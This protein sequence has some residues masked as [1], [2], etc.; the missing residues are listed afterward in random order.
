M[1]ISGL[2]K[3]YSSGLGLRHG[4]PAVADVSFSISSGGFISVIGESGSGKTTLGK[5]ILRLLRPSAGTIKYKGRDIRSLRRDELRSYYREGQGIFQDPFSSFNPLYKVDRTFRMIYENFL[6]DHD[7][8]EFEGRV[9]KVVGMVDL[10]PRE[11]LGKYPHQLSGGQLQRLL[12]ARAL[13]MDVKL[14]IADEIISMLDAS[15]RA[16]ILNLLGKLA[17]EEGMA[18]LFITHDLS[19]GYYISAETMIMYKGR[20]VEYGLSEKVFREPVH[21]YTK[22]LF[23]SVPDIAAER[24]RSAQENLVRA[25]Q[26]MSKEDFLPEA[27]ARRVREFY[28]VNHKRPKGLVEVSEGHR[29]VLTV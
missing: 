21:P 20:V 25:I 26:G 12:I 24:E 13:L 19:L 11:V 10:N 6:F 28:A 15:T 18:V 22:I 4:D 16:D 1:E 2:T 8:S 17:Y 27:I 5:L 29:A 9:E 7:W 14:L 23:A 3:F